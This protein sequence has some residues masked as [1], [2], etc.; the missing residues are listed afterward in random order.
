MADKAKLTEKQEKVLELVS[1]MTV[2]ELADLVKAM[3][4]QFGVTAAAPAVAVA[5]P[6]A[7]PVEEKSTFDVILDNVGT[8]KVAVI[9]VVKD[10]TG[11][12]LAEANTLVSSAPKAIKE[13]VSK[14]EADEIS[15][16]L[17]EAG[18]AVTV[19]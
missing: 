1:Q 4:E 19:K 11:L 3:E 17:K 10:L 9:K 12:G 14:K 5:A 2:L 8:N 7:A 15:A 18:A 16:K 13:G 6:T